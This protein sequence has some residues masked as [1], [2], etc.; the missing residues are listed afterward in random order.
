MQKHNMTVSASVSLPKTHHGK[1]Y[2]GTE[3]RRH[4]PQALVFY[5]FGEDEGGGL[6]RQTFDHRPA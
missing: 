4:G 2:T 3:D 6:Y 1:K 5:G